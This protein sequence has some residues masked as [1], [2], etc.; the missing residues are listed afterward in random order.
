M[1]QSIVLCPSIEVFTSVS[2]PDQTFMSVKAN[3]WV[4]HKWKVHVALD[5]FC[6]DV[7]HCLH[8]GVLMVTY[9]GAMHGYCSKVKASAKSFTPLK[10]LQQAFEI[11]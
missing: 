7:L 5:N 8:V 10:Q 4:A 9:T 11:P 6:M 3:K 2:V 1:A